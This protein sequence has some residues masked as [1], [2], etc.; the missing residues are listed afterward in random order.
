[1]PAQFGRVAVGT[2]HHRHRVPADERPDAVFQG[3]LLRAQPVLLFRGD[4]V[5]VRRRRDV[6]DPGALAPASRSLIQQKN[7]RSAPSNAST[8]SSAS[9][10]SRVSAGSRSSSMGS[11]SSTPGRASSEPGA[12]PSSHCLSQS[13]TDGRPGRHGP[14]LADGRMAWP[15]ASPV[16]RLHW[17]RGRRTWGARRVRSRPGQWERPWWRSSRPLA[18]WH[19]MARLT[20]RSPGRR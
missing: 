15:Y 3:Q 7:A 6:G 18:W 19:H 13:G 16:E 10:H 14:R 17:S 1:M 12:S 20:G 11:P 2:Q 4:G 9:T 8:E 5:Q